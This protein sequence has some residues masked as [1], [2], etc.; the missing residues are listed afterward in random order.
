MQSLNEEIVDLTEK[1]RR[2][3][4]Y[5]RLS[6]AAKQTIDDGIDTGDGIFNPESPHD[7]S[8]L[9]CQ[10]S[11]QETD[12]SPK[13]TAAVNRWY[14]QEK[15]RKLHHDAAGFMQ[16]APVKETL[17]HKYTN[18][19]E[20]KDELIADTSAV[21]TN[22]LYDVTVNE[23]HMLSFMQTLE[24]LII[25]SEE[26]LAS[27]YETKEMAD[28]LNDTVLTE[29]LNQQLA[30]SAAKLLP[31]D[32]AALSCLHAETLLLYWQTELAFLHE[33]EM[34]EADFSHLLDV[35]AHFFAR[36]I[37]D[38]TCHGRLTEGL[39]TIDSKIDLIRDGLTRLEAEQ[40]RIKE[41]LDSLSVQRIKLL[42]H[43]N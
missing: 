19:E 30:T 28:H 11:L 41:E 9:T 27:L 38:W 25:F 1:T 16:A 33:S 3:L 32:N 18:L 14:W 2:M 24:D 22:E 37:T 34:I 43:K 26:I 12:E 21:W 6:A 23:A 4:K 42:Y 10:L 5:N 40:F 36:T 39:K 13:L 20:R 35:S 8:V 29:Q 17:D 31:L 7:P 15:I